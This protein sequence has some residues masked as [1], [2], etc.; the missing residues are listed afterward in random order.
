M[1][2][3]RSSHIRVFIFTEK[4]TGYLKHYV[5]EDTKRLAKSHCLIL[6]ITKSSED[7]NVLE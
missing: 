4:C 6:T 7:A 2:S 3:K 1:S 5:V